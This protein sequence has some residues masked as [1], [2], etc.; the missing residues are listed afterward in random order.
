MAYK[1]IVVGTDGSERAA[2]AVGEA[3]T[4]AKGSG[5]K[6]H[7]VH[8]VSHGVATGFHDSVGGQIDVR[9]SR[10]ALDNMNAQLLA[11]AERQGVPLQVHNPGSSDVAD[12]LLSI[13][14]AVHADLVVVGNRGM[15]GMTRFVLGSVPNKVAHQCPC[16][17][18]IVNTDS[19]T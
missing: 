18:L 2:V 4:L 16:S 1:V 10:E 6:V 5:A 3:L 9:K 8:A 12:A 13:A 15:S 14:E 19:S 7:A 11:E 17:V